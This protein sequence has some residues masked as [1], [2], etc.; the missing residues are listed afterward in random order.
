MLHETVVESD[1]VLLGWIRHARLV[2]LR[3]VHGTKFSLTCEASK[4]FR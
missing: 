3:H 4:I 1:I 2:S